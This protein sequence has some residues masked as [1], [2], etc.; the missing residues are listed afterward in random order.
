MDFYTEEYERG[1]HTDQLDDD[2][3]F[4]LTK[5][6]APTLHPKK[7]AMDKSLLVFPKGTKVYIYKKGTGSVSTYQAKYNYFLVLYEHILH[8]CQSN[9]I[10]T[11]D[12]QSLLVGLDVLAQALKFEK[13]YHEEN[14]KNCIKISIALIIK[15]LQK[16]REDKTKFEIIKRCFQVFLSFAKIDPEYS[17]QILCFHN[18]LPVYLHFDLT[19]EN[20]YKKESISPSLLTHYH[21]REESRQVSHD[22]LMD[23]LQFFKYCLKVHNN[24]SI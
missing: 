9:E 23:Y 22:M 17:L 21:V 8:Y 14:M 7:K 20:V 2:R 6:Y 4:N 13:M 1:Y 3:S 19:L 12:F 24:I 11:K 18:F 5:E 16:D 10:T 15:T